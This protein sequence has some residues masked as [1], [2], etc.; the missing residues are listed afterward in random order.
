MKYTKEE[1]LKIMDN[2]KYPL[3][4]KYSPDWI[5]E[6]S[7]GSHCLW[8]TEALVTKMNLKPGMRVLDMGCGKAIS[9]VFLAKEF[10]VTVWAT[11]LWIN[12]TDN[13]RRICESGVSNSVF[14]VHADVNN[15]PY[16]DGY[17]DAMVSINSLFFYATEDGFL[18]DKL[19]RHIKPGGEIGIIVPGFKHEYT[20]NYPESYKHYI[21]NENWGL[22]NWHTAQWWKNHMEKSGLADVISADDMNGEGT[23]IFHKSINVVNAHEEPFNVISW[24]DITFSRIIAKRKTG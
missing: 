13:Y 12:P 14:P 6:N 5:L 11:D 15:L 17:F 24:D 10:G 19:L 1:I 2:D 20:G 21:E 23:E 3:T 7:M 4:Q 9:S 16:S 18:K 22:E 8:L